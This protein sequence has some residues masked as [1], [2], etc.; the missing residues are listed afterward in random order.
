MQK[1]ILI[2]VDDSSQSRSAVDYAVAMSEVIGELHFN[3]FH[4][5]PALSMYMI[6]EAEKNPRVR[7]KL[8]EIVKR[9]RIAAEAVMTNFKES[10]VAAGIDGKLGR[11][12][13]RIQD[14]RTRSRMPG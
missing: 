11:S 7:A 3:L 12:S 10:M 13:E 4:V 9:N 1:E 2:A 6:D 5:H 14:Q 8:N